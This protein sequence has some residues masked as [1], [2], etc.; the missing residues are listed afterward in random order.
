[1]DFIESFIKSTQ[2]ICRILTFYLK[3]ENGNLGY[4]FKFHKPIDGGI[5]GELALYCEVL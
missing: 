1:M 4:T 2:N 5:S 3:V